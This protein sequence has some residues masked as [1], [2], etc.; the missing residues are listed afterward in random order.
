[1]RLGEIETTRQLQVLGRD[2]TVA[3]LRE[4]LDGMNPDDKIQV[5]V[6]PGDQREP[7][8]VRFKSAV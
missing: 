2:L 5:S 4:Y 7:S 1:M 6:D 8:V 3:K